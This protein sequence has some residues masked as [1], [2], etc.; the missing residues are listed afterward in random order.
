M[1]KIN[2]CSNEQKREDYSYIEQLIF[3]KFLILIGTVFF[4]KLQK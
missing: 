4:S 1:L 2:L 3:N